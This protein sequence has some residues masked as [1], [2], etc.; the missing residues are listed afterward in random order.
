MVACVVVACAVAMVS[1]L[2]AAV[3]PAAAQGIDSTEDVTPPAL[4]SVE[5]DRTTVDVTDEAQRIDVTLRATDDLSGVQRV[6]LYYRHR[7]RGTAINASAG[8]YNRVSGDEL[9]GVYETSIYLPTT[10]AAGDYD[11][12]FVQVW[13]TVG[14]YLY[15][16]SPEPGLAPPTITVISPIDVTP[17]EIQSLTVVN[18]DI[19]VSTSLASVAVEARATDDVSGVSYL[20]VGFQSPSGRQYASATLYPRTASDPD[21]YSGPMLVAGYAEPGEWKVVSVCAVDRTRNSECWNTRTTPTAFGEFGLALNVTSDFADQTPPEMQQYNINPLDVDVTLGPETVTIDF[22]V[23]DN[24]AGVAYAY[25]Q[26]ASPRTVG[27]TP[28]VI[29]RYSYGYAPRLWN[30]VRDADGTYS[31]MRN[32]NDPLLEGVVTGTVSFPRYDRSGDWNITRVCVVDNVNWQTCYTG[33]DLAGLGPQSLEVEWNRTPT[34]AVTG[35]DAPTYPAGSEPDVGCAVNDREDGVITGV[36]PQISGPDTNGV[37]TVTC[38][39]TDSGGITSSTEA[40]YT[41]EENTDSTPPTL[42]GTP[43]TNPNTNG[44][45]S[46]DVTIEWVASDEES[47]V[48]SDTMPGPS[49]ISGDG[50]GQTATASVSDVAG[51]STTAVSVPAVNI[52]AT[53]PTVGAPTLS[54]NPKADHDVATLTAEVSDGL[55]GIAGAEFF[56]D[57]DPGEA[58]GSLMSIS[59]AVATATVG[60][61]LEAG[62]YTVSVRTVDLAGNWSDARSV[63]L[64]VYDPS[65]GFV[66]GGGW[67]DSPAGS[68]VDDPTAKGPARFGFVAKYKKGANTPDGNTEFQFH[69]GDLRFSSSSYDWLVVSGGTARYKGDGELNGAAGYS[70]KLAACDVEVNGVCSGH[71]SDTL[72]MVIWET[73]TELIVFDSTV[74]PLSG[75]SIHVHTGGKTG[76]K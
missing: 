12:Y 29:Y 34:V 65:G 42:T 14:N 25:I 13:D 46:G 56:I 69:A 3:V 62:V 33:D 68:L 55:S 21:L 76:R 47:G 54:L 59:G 38:S 19:D 39:Y 20:S 64:V 75:G 17:P 48:D 28:E 44:W 41:V 31:Y 60:A 6:R 73:S 36:E 4:V 37:V 58:N 63:M 43:T 22:E 32:T 9:D 51:N 18:P 66:T 72:R 45:Y 23:T 24:A 49:V 40:S 52:D 26:F 50:A 16:T 10:M 27:A 30:F 57:T 71:D 74:T 7:T 70:F 53:A 15:D 5:M 8:S 61:D 67:I 11:L 35:I 2:I 1:G